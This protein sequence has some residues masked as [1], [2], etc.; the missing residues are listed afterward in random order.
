MAIVYGGKRSV[1]GLQQRQPAPV[2][3]GRPRQ[4]AVGCCDGGAPPCD[5]CAEVAG[6]LLA[7]LEDLAGRGG[8]GGRAL[9]RLARAHRGG[10]LAGLGDIDMSSFVVSQS[11]ID[12]ESQAFD[13]RLNAWLGD[14]A[15]VAAR[16][17]AAFVQQVDDFVFRWRKQKDAFYFFQTS[18]LSDLMATEA[19]FNRLRDQYLGYGQSTA[20]APATVTAN[21]A[22]VR[23]DQ[24]PQ[25]TS[26]GDQVTTALKWGGVVVGG[27]VVLKVVHDTGIVTRLARK[28][29]A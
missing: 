23:A 13:G 7:G 11:S 3:G 20:V 16:L 10:Q 17:P 6:G 28:A 1:V 12:A 25:G 9:R 27:L 24:I 29:A 2:A 18:R 15:R 5:H 4:K 14:F 8:R 19:E 26:W 21:G 22:T